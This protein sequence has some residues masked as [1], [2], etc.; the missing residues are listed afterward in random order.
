MKDSKF[1]PMPWYGVQTFE[2][3]R[4][5]RN[6]NGIICAFM[7]PSR[8]PDQPKRYE[9]EME[10]IRGAE[11]IIVKAPEMYEALKQA[12]EALEQECDDETIQDIVSIVRAND[13]WKAQELLKHLFASKRAVLETIINY[14]EIN[15]RL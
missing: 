11:T 8:Y 13:F 6:E 4:A 1:P 12:K 3:G 5:I 7:L 9:L 15:A 10:E 2:G 14:L